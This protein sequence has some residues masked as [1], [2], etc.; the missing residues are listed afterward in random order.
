MAQKDTTSVETIIQNINNKQYAPI[1]YLMGEESYYINKISD[2]IASHVLSEEE[3]GFNQI[4]LYG[5]ETNIE[6]IITAAK[7]FPMMSQYQVI[8]VKE[9]QNLN[10]IDK[11]SYYIQKPQLSTILVFC[12]M[13]GTLD[14]RKKITL[15]IGEKGVLFESKKL[16]EYQLI[17]FVTTYLKR[18]KI[19]IEPKAAELITDF[20]G[21][22]LSRLSSELDK[23]II[24]TQ[25]TNSHRITAEQIEKN[26]GIS[27]D[28]NNFELKNALIERNV[29]K[30]NQIIQYFEQNPKNNPL[31]KT[32]PLLFNFFSNLM[33][34]Y[35]APQKTESGIAAQ[36]EQKN[37]WQA[38]EY[39]TA[40]QNYSGVKVM[41]IIEAIRQCDAKSKGVC[42]PSIGNGDLL[43]E[44]I[45]KILH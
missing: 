15:E 32:L 40:M 6:T 14:R 3:K 12:H 19:D 20:V 23:L 17:P 35:Y 11:L 7:R 39:L 34:A 45:F 41:H 2:Y 10:N 5:N 22:D 27:K 24:T 38:K 16:K 42:N 44:L 8:I 31:Q 9:A 29:F 13:N 30:A 4:M 36:L 1:Y 21:S 26:V 37:Q 43:K 33:L 18:K 28:F 25:S